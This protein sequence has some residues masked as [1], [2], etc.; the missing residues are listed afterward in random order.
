MF[1]FTTLAISAVTAAATMFAPLAGASP[2]SSAVCASAI[3]AGAFRPAWCGK[4]PPPKSYE[5]FR[6]ALGAY[7]ANTAWLVEAIATAIG[8]FQPINAQC[9]DNPPVD[10]TAVDVIVGG[11]YLNGNELQTAG[12][13]GA[14][15]HECGG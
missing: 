1:G 11:M 5:K 12:R 2:P 4:K 6:K 15:G 9:Q 3:D 7:Q 8:D 13:K 10:Q 14:C